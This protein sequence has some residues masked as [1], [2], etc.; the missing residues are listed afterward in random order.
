MAVEAMAEPLSAAKNVP[1]PTATS[2]RRPGTRPIHLSTAS[3]D[4]A[5]RPERVSSSPIRMKKRIGARLKLA[6]E[7]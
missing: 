3:M 1:P 2:D 4:R 6:T 7:S 5:A